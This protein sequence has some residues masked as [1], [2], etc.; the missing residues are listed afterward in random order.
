MG[1]RRHTNDTTTTTTSIGAC[2]SWP[3]A[4]A[5]AAAATSEPAA[6]TSQKLLEHVHHEKESIRTLLEDYTTKK[7]AYDDQSSFK[8]M[9]SGT[10]KR[11]AEDA[12][13]KLDSAQ[14]ALNK[15]KS[16]ADHPKLRYALRRGASRRLRHASYGLASALC[17]GC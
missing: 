6:P 1:E 17:R 15:A 10:K 4:A 11:E 7:K 8:S 12:K 16:M 14:E 13:S 3:S 9:F 5:A 2:R